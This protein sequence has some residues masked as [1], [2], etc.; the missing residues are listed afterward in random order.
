MD[1]KERIK[2]LESQIED[3]SKKIEQFQVHHLKLQGAVEILNIIEGESEKQS[4]QKLFNDVTEFLI[5]ETKFNLPEKFLKKWMSTT[6]KGNLNSDQI[7]EEYNKSEK[8]IRYK[9]IQEKIIKDQ[10]FLITNDEIK[11]HIKE[12][13]A[14][15][16]KQ[17]G[18]V[19]P[20]GDELENIIQRLMSNQ[21]EI[22][23]IS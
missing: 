6:N 16:S 18:Q 1:N 17:Y 22:S 5:Q 8:G 9:L 2:D 21:E 23:R 7:E 19:I 3:V 4:E 11:E 12:M 15:Q 14:L 13:I 10:N 20:S